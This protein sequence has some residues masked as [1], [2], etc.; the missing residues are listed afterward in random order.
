ML[1]ELRRWADTHGGVAP[2]R[3]DW[4]A[5]RDPGRAWP[6]S[7][8]VATLFQREAV[9]DGVRKPI[10]ARCDICQCREGRHYTNDAGHSMWIGCFDCRGEC[11]HGGPDGYS[12]PTGWQYALQLA[13]LDV[14]T[15]G[16]HHATSAQKL[17]RNRQMV[18]GGVA[19]QH[20]QRFTP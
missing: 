8:R 20:P 11:P 10:Y 3:A 14:R 15:G 4:S 2:S 19:D 1:D 13:G 5:A 16:D 9:L 17:G 12:G 7:E 18:T 6:R